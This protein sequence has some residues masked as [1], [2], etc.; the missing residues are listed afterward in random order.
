M[1]LTGVRDVHVDLGHVGIFRGLIAQADLGAEFEAE[2]FDALQRKAVPEMRQL[3]AGRPM[4]E[5]LRAM[6]LALADLNGG[7]EVLAQAREALRAAA[8]PVQAALQEL[9]RMADLLARRQPELPLHFDLAELR[10][11]NYQTGIVFGAF[12]PGHGQEVARGGRYDDIGRIFGRSRP[13]TGF[14]ADLK[15]LVALSAA[16]PPADESR[17]IFAPAD[18][19]GALHAKVRDLRAAGERVVCAL[20]GQHGGASDMGCDRVLER[21]DGAWMVIDAGDGK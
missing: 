16:L 17:P 9:E 19:D 1:A 5:K 18:D 7:A 20:P 14:S 21:R 3:L 6:L 13:A 4:D 10:G 11:Y 8:A 12:V 15:T 2:L